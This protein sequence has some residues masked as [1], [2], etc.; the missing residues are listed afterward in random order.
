MFHPEYGTK[1]YTVFIVTDGGILRSDN[2]RGTVGHNLCG[3]AP[4]GAVKWKESNTGLSTLQF[5]SGALFPDAKRYLGGTQDNGTYFGQSV[6]GLNSLENQE[7]SEIISGDGGTTLVDPINTNNVYATLPPGSSAQIYKSYTGPNG[8]FKL[9]VASLAGR[10]S[11][12]TPLA[13]DPSS[14]ARLWAGGDKIYRTVDAADSW[15]PASNLLTKDNYGTEDSGIVTSIA[16]SPHDSNIVVA[17]TD[18]NVNSGVGGW[19]LATEQALAADENTTWHRSRPRKG[20]VSSI[21]FDPADPKVVYVTYSSFNSDL[22]QGHVFRSDNSGSPPWIAV[23]GP[24]KAGTSPKNSCGSSP[25]AIPDIPVHTIVVD[26]QNP[27]RIWI[28][29]DIGVFTSIDRGATWKEENSGFRVP[30]AA[31]VLSSDRKSLFAFTH[32]RGVW[33]VSIQ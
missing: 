21:T 13:M 8:S 1:N 9:A 28:G 33:K 30:V 11:F 20:W 31:L 29:T 3:D 15:H 14:S 27:R 22:D 10:F 26:P 18:Y 4:A 32:G 19:V 5:Y 24:C 6:P 2:S 25:D 17:G 7:W 12:V 23:D 16:V